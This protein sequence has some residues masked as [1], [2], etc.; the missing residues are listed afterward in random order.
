MIST[1]TTYITCAKCSLY[2]TKHSNHLY[3]LMSLDLFAIQNKE[4]M[5]YKIDL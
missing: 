5:I 3:T 4:T 2:D 1:F